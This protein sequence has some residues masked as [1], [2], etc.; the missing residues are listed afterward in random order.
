MKSKQHGAQI[1]C[2]P[3]ASGTFSSVAEIT[4]SGF[5]A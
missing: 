3:Y 4:L 5:G 1:F 2:I